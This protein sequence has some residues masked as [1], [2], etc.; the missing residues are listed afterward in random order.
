MRFRSFFFARYIDWIVTT[1]LLLLDL[2]LL[3]GLSSN[4]INTLIAYDV[5]MIVTGLMGALTT[6]SAK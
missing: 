3:A 2:F 5:M 6:T 1:P 4:E